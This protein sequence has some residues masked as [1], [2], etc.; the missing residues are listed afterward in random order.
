MGDFAERKPDDPVCPIS[1]K[2]KL[3]YLADMLGELK[4][5]AEDEHC[6]ILSGLLALSHSEALRCSV[7]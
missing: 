5:I 1:R 6:E 2:D 3:A 4:T 7:R